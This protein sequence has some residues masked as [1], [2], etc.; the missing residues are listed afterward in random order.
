[1]TLGPRD[2]LSSGV[3]NSCYSSWDPK[4]SREILLMEKSHG[5]LEKKRCTVQ[6]SRFHGRITKSRPREDETRLLS[7]QR[8]GRLPLILG[9]SHTIRAGACP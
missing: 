5:F 7:P 8:T 1:M 4:I 3:L 2:V 9:S 6:V